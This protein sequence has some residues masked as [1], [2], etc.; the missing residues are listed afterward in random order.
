MPVHEVPGMCL[1]PLKQDYCWQRLLGQFLTCHPL[2]V[3]SCSSCRAGTSALSPGIRLS[4]H[5]TPSCPPT[6]QRLKSQA[7]QWSTMVVK[8]RSFSRT[9]TCPAWQ[10]RGCTAQWAPFRHWAE[11]STASHHPLTSTYG[12]AVGG[13]GRPH[14]GMRR[15]S[16]PIQTRS[17]CLT[18]HLHAFVFSFLLFL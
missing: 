2:H 17:P 14:S 4:L 5:S 16:H 6:W 15:L 12:P 9:R 11:P 7:C 3:I 13:D 18:Q 1:A 8:R 10:S